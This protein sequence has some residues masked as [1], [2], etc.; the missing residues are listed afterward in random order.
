MKK[1][2]KIVSVLLVMVLVLVAMT[3]CGSGNSSGSADNQSSA[4]SSEGTGKV[5]NIGIVQQL[6]HPALDEATEGFQQALVDKLGEDGVKFDLQNA[7]NEQANCTTISQGFVSQNVDLILANATTAL[8][9][10]AAATADIPIVGTSITDYAT[11]LN[12]DDWSGSTGTNVTGT[13]DLAPLEEQAAMILE[14]VPDAKQ[15]GLLYCSAEPNSV[16]QIKQVEKYLDEH[17]VAYKEYGA[18]D[19]NEIQA[20]T[21]TAVN[22]CDVLYIPTDNT[23]AGSTE[24]VNNVALPAKVPVIA[25]EEGICE[26]C[27]IAT[28]T[29]DY[30]D[31]GYEAGL[32]AYEILVNGDDPGTM[33][34]RTAEN[35]VK[36]YNPEICTALNIT[37]PDGYEAIETEADAE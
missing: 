11:A 33:E 24:A 29:I 12:I 21:T 27:G 3:G 1:K 19:S 34:I 30:Y 26:G 35:V 6:E 2:S 9:S 25:G 36:K 18:A 15:V 17:D 32:M 22:E 20:V 16:Y 31:I 8:Q 23:M 4:G 14:L 13:S 37:V 28:L 5:Y 10:A 7:Q